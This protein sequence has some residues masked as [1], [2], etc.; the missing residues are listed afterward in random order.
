MKNITAFAFTVLYSIISNAQ[1]AVN[2]DSLIDANLKFA[3]KQYKLLEKNVPNNLMP[4]NYDPAKAKWKPAIPNGGAA[5][6]FRVRC[7]TSMNTQKT[8]R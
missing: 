1:Q 3:A 7:G 5:V 6:S 4:R 2:M 8:N